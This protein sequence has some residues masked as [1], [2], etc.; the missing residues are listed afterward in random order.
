MTMKNK[1]FIG[2]DPGQPAI[3]VNCFNSAHDRLAQGTDTEREKIRPG[4]EA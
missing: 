4:R 1:G 2:G 3:A